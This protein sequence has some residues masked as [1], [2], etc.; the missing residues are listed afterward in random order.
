MTTD[1]QSPNPEMVS[2]PI[3]ELD[4]T[5]CICIDDYFIN[6][7]E[8][9][10]KITINK[11]NEKLDNFN[12]KLD[13]N[14][15]IISEKLDNNLNNL[16]EENKRLFQENKTLLEEN[17]KLNEKLINESLEN[18]K[19]QK[20][21]KYLKEITYLLGKDIKCEDLTDLK[22]KIILLNNRK[23]RTGATFKFDS[24]LTL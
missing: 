18:D 17:K 19:L 7:N 21:N 23:L 11:I 16:I 22:N 9:I 1:I 10:N 6:K 8:N 2:R 24:L 15:S 13:N 20:T 5:L 3:R 4:D 12:E 14:L